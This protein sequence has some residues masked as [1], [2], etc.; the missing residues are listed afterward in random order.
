MPEMPSTH[1]K[2][3]WRAGVILP[4]NHAVISGLRV[5]KIFDTTTGIREPISRKFKLFGLFVV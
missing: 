5:E 1:V 2:Y 4:Q 3:L